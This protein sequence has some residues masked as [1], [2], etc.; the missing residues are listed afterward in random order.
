MRG[1]KHVFLLKQKYVFKPPLTPTLSPKGEKEKKRMIAPLIMGNTLE[2][3]TLIHD[4]KGLAL[5]DETHREFK[6]VRVDFASDKLTHRRLS[7]GGK[8]QSIAKA[9]GLKG[10]FV[11]TV[12]DVTAGLGQDSFVLASLG[13]TV[14]MLERQPLVAQLLAD[15]LKRGADNPDIAAIMSRMSFE[16]ADAIGWLNSPRQQFDVVYMDPMFPERVKSAAVK[17]EMQM[18]HTLVGDDADSPSLLVAALK[19]AT[20]RVVVKRPRLA[21]V[22]D[23]PKPDI[24]FQGKTCRFDVYLRVR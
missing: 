16:V 4:E 8:K 18:F 9:V 22:I 13:C 23:G 6:P 3:F 19:V 10:G 21:P 7:G 1:L 24:E 2:K 17:K 14:H 11:P 15:G 20:K 12:L 5:Q